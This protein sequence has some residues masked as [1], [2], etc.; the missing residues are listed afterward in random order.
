MNH[1]CTY[2]CKYTKAGRKY[3][4]LGPKWNLNILLFARDPTKS[5]TIFKIIV[6]KT[7]K[8]ISFDGFLMASPEFVC[9]IPLVFSFARAQST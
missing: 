3:Y 5:L 8:V 6:K 4:T 1:D 9:K 7:L 2:A